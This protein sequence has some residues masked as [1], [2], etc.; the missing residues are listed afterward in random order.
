[1]TA[2]SNSGYVLNI[3]ITSTAAAPLHT[4]DS[5][6]AVPGKGLEGDRYFTQ[7]GTFAKS[8][9]PFTPDREVSLM[10]SEALDG[11]KREYGISLDPV[12]TRRNIIT[13]GVALNHL[14]G[15][16]FSVGPVRLRGLRLCEPCGHLEGLTKENVR[17]GLVHRGGL[18]CAVL[19]EGIISVGDPVDVNLSAGAVS[20]APTRVRARV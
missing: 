19:T 1:M 18:R 9:K 20:P 16:E 3:C 4:V 17:K 5:A 2:T 8:G 15:R 12:D 6:R 13:R 7:S 14:V 10:E 11:L